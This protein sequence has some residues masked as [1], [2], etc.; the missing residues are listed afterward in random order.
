MSPPTPKKRIFKNMEIKTIKRDKKF[1]R[2][3]KNIEKITYNW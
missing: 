2:Q 1:L 3:I